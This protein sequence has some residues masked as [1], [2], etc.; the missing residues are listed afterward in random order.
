M[1]ATATSNKRRDGPKSDAKSPQT[2][3]TTEYCA[4]LQRW[5]WQSYWGYANWQSWSAL[6]AFPP[7]C[8]FPPPGTSGQTPGTHASTSNGQQPFDT[9][10]WY[11][12][13][14]PLSFPTSSSHPAGA[15]TGQSSAAT[16]TPGADA[17]PAQQQNGNPPQ[18]GMSQCDS[19]L[20]QCCVQY[21]VLTLYQLGHGSGKKQA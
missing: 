6:S 13:P 8:S 14:N 11:S 2:T 18:A 5:I 15:Q 20:L 12:Y 16:P 7:P 19:G 9:G 4:E 3:A 10:N 1:F 21:C 17:R